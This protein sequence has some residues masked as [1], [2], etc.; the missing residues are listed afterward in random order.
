MT[1]SSIWVVVEPAGD[2]LTTTSTELLSHARS[3]SDDVRAITWGNASALAAEAGEFG[4]STLYDVGDLAGA[5]LDR[6][7]RVVEQDFDVGQRS[8]TLLDQA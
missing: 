3:L 6:D 4:A 2:A 1:L 5:L 8:Q 7:D